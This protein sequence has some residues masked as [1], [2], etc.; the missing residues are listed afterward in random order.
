[1]REQD[2]LRLI[3]KDFLKDTGFKQSVLSEKLGLAPGTLACFKCGNFDLSKDKAE[4][5][6]N[7]IERIEN[8]C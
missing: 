7:L 8:I 6:L 5:L 2:T 3:L 4:E 1:M